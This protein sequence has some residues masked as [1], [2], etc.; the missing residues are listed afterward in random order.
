MAYT[1]KLDTEIVLPIINEFGL[2][3]YKLSTATIE[4][5]DVKAYYSYTDSAGEMV[6]DYTWLIMVSGAALLVNDTYATIDG[7]LNP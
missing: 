6:N 3:N 7:L 4:L 1:I 5:N 2:Y